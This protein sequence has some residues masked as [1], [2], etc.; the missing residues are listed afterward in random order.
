MLFSLVVLAVASPP[1][2][3]EWFRSDAEKIQQMRY[4]LYGLKV[5]AKIYS[6][7]YMQRHAVTT[8]RILLHGILCCVERAGRVFFLVCR[9]ARM[10]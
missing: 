5:D 8:A 7:E 2:N 6:L 1:F 9:Y 10:S 4:V 3:S